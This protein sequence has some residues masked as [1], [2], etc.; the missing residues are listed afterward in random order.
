MHYDF[1]L[2]WTKSRDSINT[3]TDT[4]RGKKTTTE[5][6]SCHFKITNRSHQTLDGLEAHWQIYYNKTNG[7]NTTLEHKDGVKKIPLI[8]P[9]ENIT[10]DTDPIQLNTVQMIDGLVYTDGTPAKYFDTFK[11]VSMRLV[12]DGETVFEN[13][14]NGISKSAETVSKKSK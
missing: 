8:K 2:T 6:W 11:G 12:R 7:K 13:T 5:K 1:A 10:V 3:K 4:N 14:T 9:M